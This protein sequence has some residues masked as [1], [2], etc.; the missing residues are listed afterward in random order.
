MS[1]CTQ[2]VELG[3]TA[4][5][6]ERR[7][8]ELSV[9][10]RVDD[11]VDHR[12]DDEPARDAVRR[13]RTAE[14]FA[15]RAPDEHVRAA[16]DERRQVG[17]ER[18]DVEQRAGVEEHVRG[19]DA[20]PRRHEQ[21][22]RDQRTGRQHRRVRSAVESCGVDEQ[23]RCVRG[24]VR[25]GIGAAARSDELLVLAGPRALGVVADPEGF[26]PG[27]RPARPHRRPD[28]L[29]LPHD[30]RRREIVD[31]ERELVGLLAPVRRTEHRPDLA[32]G[33]QQLLDAE[34]VL[35]QPQ[36]A[37]ARSEAG[38]A[39]RVR[40]AMDAR[41]RGLPVQRQV[42]VR[43]RGRVGPGA[44]VTAQHIGEGTAVGRHRAN[45]T[46]PP[47]QGTRRPNRNRAPRSA[48]DCYPLN[49]LL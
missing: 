18:P 13:D 30:D 41:R 10:V 15:V 31:D 44:G 49:C 22:L 45:L 23:E 25:V 3:V 5:A 24:R 34:R 27:T 7:K 36:H 39:Q 40:G 14:V 17:H 11:R 1:G 46:L 20:R 16:H 43:E 35:P 21:A 32:A 38:R 33:E 47:K 9:G 29:L 12:P 26:V 28:L 37:V 8:V 19:V 42:T 2:R 4:L 48:P 6:A